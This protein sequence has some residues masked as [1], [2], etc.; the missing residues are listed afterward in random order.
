VKADL[1][2]EITTVYINSCV[3]TSKLLSCS[4]D[5]QQNAPCQKENICIITFE[6]KLKII[7]NRDKYK[8]YL[9]PL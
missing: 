2:A 5:K 9:Q 8:K 7:Q 1:K 6:D 4:Q 3:T